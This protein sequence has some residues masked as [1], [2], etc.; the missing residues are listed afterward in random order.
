MLWI[1]GS[2]PLPPESCVGKCP[3]LPIPRS[4]LEISSRIW[5]ILL[6]IAEVQ[7]IYPQRWIPASP[8]RF[9]RLNCWQS[10]QAGT[11]I[12]CV[13][14]MPCKTLFPKPLLLMVLTL[15]NLL[16]DWNWVDCIVKHTE[17][18]VDTVI[19]LVIKKVPLE[20]DSRLRDE[21]EKINSV[22]SNDSY[23]IVE[24]SVLLWGGK[25]DELQA[26]PGPPSEAQLFLM[27]QKF[28]YF[29]YKRCSLPPPG[30]RNFGEG[31][32]LQLHTE[33][34]LCCCSAAHLLPLGLPLWQREVHPPVVGLR[35]RQ[36]LWG[37]FWWTGLP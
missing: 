31:S 27:T 28:M 5:I 21:R 8:C 34:S 16:C 14:H 7:W 15:K 25:A 13:F 20:D 9:F 36:R 26:Y 6:P 22:G 37:W 4:L 24:R 32:W 11:C 29:V 23:S 19:F 33:V 10:P 1:C 3:T 2:T 30:G 12:L 17:K 35:W 18:N